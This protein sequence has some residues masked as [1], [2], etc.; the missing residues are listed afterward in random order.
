MDA[1]IVGDLNKERSSWKAGGGL[2]QVFDP[3][4]FR[5]LLMIMGSSSPSS[6]ELFRRSKV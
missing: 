2:G 5:R 6:Y 3:V 1:T 4:T